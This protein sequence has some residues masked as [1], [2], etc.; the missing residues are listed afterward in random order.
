MI[1]PNH[2]VAES[3]FTNN[4]MKCNCKY[5]GHRIWFHNCHVGE[6][7]YQILMSN[8]ALI[9]TFPT[10]SLIV[11][12][13]FQVTRSV[14]RQRGGLRNT[15]DSWITRFLNQQ[16]CQ[17]QNEAQTLCLQWISPHISRLFGKSQWMC[18]M[19]GFIILEYS[20]AFSLMWPNAIFFITK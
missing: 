16:Q 1:N 9:S 17:Q 3:D 15:P 11:F 12:Y 4:A 13:P 20:S 2:E 14:R 19:S 7:K 5:D 10:A 8:V 18:C 6:Q